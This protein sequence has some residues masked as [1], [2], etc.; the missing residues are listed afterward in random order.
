M[1]KIILIN[2]TDG[3]NKF[4]SAEIDP[5]TITITR[6]WG[7]LGT[8]GSRKSQAFGSISSA[9]SYIASKKKEKINEG[10]KEV[11]SLELHK[12]EIES[13]ILGTR[14]KCCASLWVRT[15]GPRFELIHTS[16]LQ[17]PDCQVGL[18][19]ILQ[20]HKTY[21]NY[22]HHYFVFTNDGILKYDLNCYPLLTEFLWKLDDLREEPTQEV[23]DKYLSAFPPKSVNNI[24]YDNFSLAGV[25]IQPDDELY[26]LIEKVELAVATCLN[27]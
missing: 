15:V 26:P 22:N 4:W 2:K 16:R 14:N 7:R 6:S 23:L 11:S 10:Y 18:F 13:A 20:T 19:I 12:A 21:N 27:Q 1:N 5:K 8:K 25:S 3:H 17:E 24:T 9:E